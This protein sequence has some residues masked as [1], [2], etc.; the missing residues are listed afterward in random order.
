MPEKVWEQDVARP[1]HFVPDDELAIGQLLQKLVDV[2]SRVVWQYLDSDASRPILEAPFLVGNSVQVAKDEA[3]QWIALGEPF[4]L[5]PVR[6]LNTRPRH[7]A[8]SP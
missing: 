5:A 2:W 7:L 4:V 8:S 1:A 6:R 3:G